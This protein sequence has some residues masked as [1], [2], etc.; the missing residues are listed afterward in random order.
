VSLSPDRP[1]RERE[2]VINTFG[3]CSVCEA[4]KDVLLYIIGLVGGTYLLW[5]TLTWRLLRSFHHPNYFVRTQAARHPTPAS[6]ACHGRSPH[7][8]L[9]A[10]TTVVK[11]SGRRKRS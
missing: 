8:L 4:Y 11:G 10:I 6:Q 2:L 1:T 9:G 7:G 5:A 3:R